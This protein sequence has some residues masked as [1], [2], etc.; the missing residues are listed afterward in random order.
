MDAPWVT[1]SRPPASETGNAVSTPFTWLRGE[2]GRQT[3]L[4]TGEA[5]AQP[6]PPVSLPHP[7]LAGSCKAVPMADGHTVI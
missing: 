7:A 3:P 1:E 2:G 5:E 4:V 6:R